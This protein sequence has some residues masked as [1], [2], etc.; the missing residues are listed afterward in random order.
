MAL[1]DVIGV[2]PTDNIKWLKLS[3]KGD[4]GLTQKGLY[5][6]VTAYVIDDVVNY[7]GSAYICIQNSTGNLPTNNTYWNLLISKGDAGVGLVYRGEYSASTA[8]VI[9]DLVSRYGST[10]YCKQNNTG[11]LPEGDTTQTYWNVYIAGGGENLGDLQTTNKTSLVSAVNE[12]N[13]NTN[14]NTT[15][16]GTLSSLTTTEKINLV[17]AVNEVKNQVNT[18]ETDTLKHVN[19]TNCIEIGVNA[20]AEGDSTKAIGVNSHTEGSNTV[21]S[22]FNSHAEGRYSLACFG[23][24]HKITAFDDTLKTITLDNT[25]ALAVG[26]LLDIKISDSISALDIPVTAI[27]GLVVTLN[28]VLTITYNWKYAIEK[29]SVNEFP[30]HA[31]GENTTVSGRY[32]H[33]EGNNSLARGE[34]SHAECNS[35]ASGDYSHAEGGGTIASGFGSHAEGSFTTASGQYSHSAGYY[36]QAKYAQTAIGQFSTISSASDTSYVTTAEA[37]M[38]G[39]GTSIGARGL[40]FKVLFNGNTY[41]DAAY[42][43]TGA[44]YAEYFE[45]CDGN[46]NTEDRV[47]YFVT[48]D[49]DKIRKS[50][51]IDNYILGIVSAT[52]S[53]VGDNQD[54]HWQGKYLTDDWGRVQYHNVIIPDELDN[55]GNI[56]NPEHIE[57]HPIYNPDWDGS[58]EY[59][60]REKRKEWS[61]I[62][63]MG[64]LFVRDDGTCIVD[65]YC[66]SNDNGIATSSESGYR[67]MKRVSENIVQI[68]IK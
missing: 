52:P 15:S 9:N 35:E 27:N 68:L 8:Y 63:M 62:G 42:T 17:G 43:S 48:L 36:T 18:H 29:N 26:N 6:G 20:N 45:W 64:K 4:R 1:Q 16:I 28:T 44:D 34:A 60:S 59:I 50:T 58:V 56:I 37:F 19:E 14:T 40:A 10:Y 66:K 54:D 55:E 11:V 47:G 38:I 31:E 61:A 5:S 39:N 7:N 21:A 65:G 57:I 13:T 12:V 23:T 22:T 51:S 33:V 32:S 53:V 3:S 67:V 25:T 41:A 46:I 30:V 2:L 24:F 49:G